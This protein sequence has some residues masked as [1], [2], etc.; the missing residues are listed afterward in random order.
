MAIKR[1]VAPKVTTKVA[2]NEN[3]GGNKVNAVH[4]AVTQQILN[5]LE[6][7]DL[8]PWAAGWNRQMVMPRSILTGKPYQGWNQIAFLIDM[9][10]NGYDNPFYISQ[11]AARTAGIDFPF[12]K[13]AWGNAYIVKTEEDKET[14]EERVVYSRLKGF[15]VLN[16]EVVPEEDRPPVP[17][18]WENLVF[19]DGVEDNERADYII[20]RFF[21][22]ENHSNAPALDKSAKAWYKP[23]DHRVGIPAKKRGKSTN[24][25]YGTTFHEM[26]HATGHSSMLTRFGVKNDVPHLINH[27]YSF[28]ELVA[29]IGSMMMLAYLGMSDDRDTVNSAAYIAGWAKS[30]QDENHVN[31]IISASNKA[32]KA[33]EY[34]LNVA[35]VQFAEYTAEEKAE[36][37]EVIPPYEAKAKK[38]GIV[39]R[40]KERVKKKAE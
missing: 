5:M 19:P 25:Y 7:G 30:L 6:A 24:G 35:G 37:E 2:V 38:K 20:D 8:P 39:K 12:D 4:A 40:I 22:K 3:N 16:L 18:E 21:D 26:I 31:W 27:E 14:G 32:K 13:T 23:A 1:R 28:E 33:V 9:I 15:R 29:E 34:I 11:G 10:Q 17:M 36:I